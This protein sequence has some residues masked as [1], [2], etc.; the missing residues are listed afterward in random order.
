MIAAGAS[1]RSWSTGTR[2]ADGLL[3][4]PFALTIEHAPDAPAR[5]EQPPD[6]PA[7]ELTVSEETAR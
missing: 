6:E 3:E 2:P 4:L 1:R 7:E 5:E